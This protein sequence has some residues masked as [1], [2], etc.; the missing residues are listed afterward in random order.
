MEVFEDRNI[1]LDRSRLPFR[2]LPFRA[3]S[4][5]TYTEQRL[6]LFLVLAAA[7]TR[8]RNHTHCVGA[9]TYSAERVGRTRHVAHY[10][11]TRVERPAGAMP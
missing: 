1:Q 4:L 5:Q 3:L 10:S 11:E 2:G 7:C 6:P 9:F 8:T